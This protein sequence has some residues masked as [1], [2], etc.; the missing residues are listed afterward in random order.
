MSRHECPGEEC[1]ICARAI[2]AAEDRRRNYYA[3][4]TDREL[5]HMADAAAADAFYG[6]EWS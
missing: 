6:R 4:Y 2:D 1:G 5:D 3:D